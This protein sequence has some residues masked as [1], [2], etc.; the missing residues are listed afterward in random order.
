MTDSETGYNLVIDPMNT[1]REDSL[2][3]S[4]IGSYLV[5]LVSIMIL[6][7]AVILFG[8]ILGASVQHEGERE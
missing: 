3:G 5:V 7:I 2:I 6:I 1:L 8:W 4:P